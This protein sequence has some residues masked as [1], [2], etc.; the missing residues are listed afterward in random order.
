MAHEAFH[1][2]PINVT[3]S[4]LL[5]V[6]DIAQVIMPGSDTYTI[7]SISASCRLLT[8]GTATLVC[9]NGA[10]STVTSI[11]LT[12]GAI[13]AGTLSISTITGGDKFRLGF[14]GIGIGL[15]DVIA[16]IWIKMPS[17]A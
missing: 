10:G 5:A 1:M 9:K 13:V 12:A 2:V 8:S 17:T 3:L 6:D 11:V 16:T 15:A 7:T 4:S 14:S